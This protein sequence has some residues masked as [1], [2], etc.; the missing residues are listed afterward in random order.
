MEYL[1]LTAE[2]QAEGIETSI[3]IVVLTSL[4]RKRVE[5]RCL[6][7][8]EAAEVEVV[9]DAAH[10]VVDGRMVHAVGIDHRSVRVA[11]HAEHTVEGPLP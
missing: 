10:K 4:H 8:P 7:Q 6:D 3:L 1:P 5:Q 2:K 9:A 11:G